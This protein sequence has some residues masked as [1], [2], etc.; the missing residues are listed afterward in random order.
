M[1]SNDFF[2]F[3]ER[4]CL[5]PESLLLR[6]SNLEESHFMG[7]D[8]WIGCLHFGSQ[9]RIEGLFDIRP[10]SLNPKRKTKVWIWNTIILLIVTY[11][12][13]CLKT[14]KDLLKKKQ[15]EKREIFKAAISKKKKRKKENKKL[16]IKTYNILIT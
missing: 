15:N 6:M 16:N 5:L 8:P 10:S 1:P 14:L 13:T 7:I 4:H 9:N 12:G 2:N 11:K 3:M